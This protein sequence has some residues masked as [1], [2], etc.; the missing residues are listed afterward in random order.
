VRQNFHV[1]SQI[2]EERKRTM[3]FKPPDDPL[4]AN[5]H[6]GEGSFAALLGLARSARIFRLYD[7]RLLA[8]VGGGDRYQ[9]YRLDSVG[10]R[11][12]LI[13]E[14]LVDHDDPPAERAIKCVVSVL[15]DNAQWNRDAPG[16]FVRVGHDGDDDGNVSTYFLDLGDPS[17]R[18][19]QIRADGWTVVDRAGVQ[20]R[21]PRG[22]LPLPMPSRGGSI[23]LLRPYVNLDNGDFRV[24]IAWLVAAIRPFGPYPVL[25]LSGDTG[26][27]KSTLTTVLRLLIDPQDNPLWAR[28]HNTR[29]LM[30][31]AVNGWLLAFDHLHVLP[32]WMAERLCQLGSGTGLAARPPFYSN[33][34]SV[35]HAQRP[36]VLN[37]IED[38]EQHGDLIEQ[39]VFL[40]L[41]PIGDTRRTEE[42]Y[43]RSFLADYPRILG[44][45]LDAVVAAWE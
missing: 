28:L 25:A 16:F 42:E 3:L 5:S 10:F 44:G 4:F 9:I 17:G 26:T 30:A 1:T 45:V 15:E 31:I 40:H 33:E 34:W 12:W 6:D 20:F 39:T 29:D 8:G 21:R 38:L 24:L 32:D 14:Y 35:S 18:A 2:I 41:P 43:W 19:V 23:D 36:V 37:G 11:E 7:G 27:G 22:Q 13:Q